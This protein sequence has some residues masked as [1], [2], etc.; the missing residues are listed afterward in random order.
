MAE[1]TL[2][3]LAIIGG[4]INGAAIARDASGRGLK[5]LLLEKGDL[6]CETSSASSKLVHGGLR[7]L[8]HLEFRL[9]REALLER[10]VLLQSAP[11][12][13]WPLRIVLPHNTNLRPAWMLRLGLFLYDNLGARKILPGTE[14]VD[15]H[16]P[17]YAGILQEH[18][19][20]GFS[21]ADC[22]TDDA[23]MVVLNALDA[24]ERGADIRVRTRCSGL[25]RE[26]AH[27][28]ITAETAEGEKQFQAR[29]VVNAAGMAVDD[30]LNRAYPG[31]N[32]QNLRLVKG[33]HIVVRRLYLGEHLYMF[34][35]SDKRIVFAIPYERDFTLIGTTDTPYD[36]ADGPPEI[37]EAETEYLL[38]IANEYF[39]TPVTRQDIVW[40]Y[41]G[42]RP[43]YDD[44][45]D[46]ASTVTRDYVFDLDAPEDGAALLSIFG[47]K[48][49]TCRKLAEHA[50][51]K[52]ADPLGLSEDSGPEKPGWT[53]HKALP[54]GDIADA[55]FDA[56]FAELEASYLWMPQ[57][58]LWRMGRCYGTRIHNIIGNCD[59]MEQ[60]GA[61]FGGG[62][63]EAEVRYLVD[64]EW[65]REAEDILWRR[66]KCGLHMSEAE[67]ADFHEW[68]AKSFTRRRE[69]AES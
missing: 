33:S 40:T 9:V 18:L 37:S 63:S 41:S 35:N 39:A 29:A 61:Q 25:K 67:Q 11:H 20:K 54:G 6:A 34:Q 2:Y 28:H 47:G 62:L 32:R 5:V 50:M 15:L 31:S 17:P 13:I 53:A 30:I 51:E 26:D 58:M 43:L 60:L 27:W 23:R 66:T 46:N 8:E 68:F 4:G 57:D 3:D 10:E 65:A 64:Q 42:V 7:Y 45:A 49:T 14:T 52:L 16:Q 44:K 21:F 12:I 38:S 69:D 24:A 48:I 56:F 36:P 22:W 1:N 55:D 19:Q 59:R